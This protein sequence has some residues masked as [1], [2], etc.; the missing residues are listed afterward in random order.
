MFGTFAPY[1]IWHHPHELQTR[2]PPILHDIQELTGEYVRR[3]RDNHKI[4]LWLFCARLKYLTC[5][6]R[7]NTLLPD[8]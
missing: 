5:D 3:S 8:Q 4:A 6:R 7:A 2:A 1:A